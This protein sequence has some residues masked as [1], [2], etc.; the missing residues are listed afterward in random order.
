MGTLVTAAGPHGG[1][2]DAKRLSWPIPDLA[3]IHAASVD[4]LDRA[5][6]R[7][8][9]GA[10]A[11]TRAA[12]ACSRSLSVALAA[13][14]AQGILGYVQ[15]ARAS[16]SCSSGST[17][18]ARCSCSGRVQWLLLEMRVPVEP[19]VTAPP[20]HVE[21][22][23]SRR[24]SPAAR[25]RPG[26]DAGPTRARSPD[27]WCQAPGRASASG[28]RHLRAVPAVPRAAPRAPR[29]RRASRSAA[30]RAVVTSVFGMLE[31]GATHLGVAT[32]HVIESFRNDL[33]ATL[34]DGRGH[35]PAAD[36]SS[37]CSR[38]RSPRSASRCGRW[39]TS[40]PTTRSRA[41]PRVAAA[42][43][44]GRAGDH[45]HARQGS[46]AVR[47]RQGRAARPPARHPARRRRRAREVRRR[48]RR[49]SPT[50][51]RSSV[52]APTA[53]PGLPGF[54]AKTAA[55]VLD[56]LRPPRSDPRRRP[57]TWDVAGVRGVDRLATTLATGRDVADRF[58]V[59]ATLRTDADVGTVDDWEWTGPDARASRHGASGSARRDSPPASRSWRRNEECSPMTRC[60]HRSSRCGRASR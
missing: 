47:R 21:P 34:Q 59:L 4:T 38:T 19:A 40:K 26:I 35:R 16:P 53:S 18:R 3:R 24:T 31:E 22:D 10:R 14:V 25:S 6:P 36:R 20:A 57:P 23:S 11:R 30:T 43:D 46:R 49:R 50:G 55:A 60:G 29:P 32:D 1:D 13:M 27:S 8:R 12:A 33:W 7:A 56:A 15:Y 45:L 17:S 51:S 54:G 2:A 44:R 9:R 42:D 39:S 37:R 28:R 5:R 52:T 58:K 41:P 48:R